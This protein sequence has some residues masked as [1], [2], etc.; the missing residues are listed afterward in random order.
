MSQLEKVCNE[1]ID[2]LDKASALMKT[3]RDKG[4]CFEAAQ[5]ASELSKMCQT[6]PYEGDVFSI[7][8]EDLMVE[9]EDPALPDDLFSPKQMMK[10]IL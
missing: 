10:E 7:R 8:M 3:I 4:P 5:A 2:Q 9:L 6:L 1:I